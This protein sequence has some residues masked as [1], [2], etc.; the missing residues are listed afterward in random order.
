MVP[1]QN[2]DSLSEYPIEMVSAVAIEAARQAELACAFLNFL[3]IP[4][5]KNLPAAFL[6]HLGAAMRLISW[7]SHGFFFHGDGSVP[8]GK[9]AIR[10]AFRSLAAPKADPTG[11]CVNVLRLSIERFAWTGQRDL[12]ADMALDDITDDAALDALAEFLWAS[13]HI[14]SVTGGNFGELSS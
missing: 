10:D 12:H 2:C 9:E 5:S 3:G 8:E 13:R 4:A 1:Y 6:L 14:G 7:E 11:L